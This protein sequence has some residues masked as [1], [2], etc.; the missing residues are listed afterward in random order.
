MKPT[1]ATTSLLLVLAL[2]LAFVACARPPGGNGQDNPGGDPDNPPGS[3]GEVQIPDS[4]VSALFDD[5]EAWI[6][7]L[8][9]VAVGAF[10]G[11]VEFVVAQSEGGAQACVGVDPEAGVVVEG[12]T[13]RLA[14]RFTDLAGSG[15]C[16][17][18]VTGNVAECNPGGSVPRTCAMTG[19]TSSVS[20]GGGQSV[21][22]GDGQITRLSKCDAFAVSLETS[23]EWA[24][25]N[26]HP[27][28]SQVIPSAQSIGAIVL[29]A[30]NGGETVAANVV[31]DEVNVVGC[32]DENPS[33]PVTLSGGRLQIGMELQ[34]Q[35]NRDNAGTEGSCGIEFD[36]VVSYCAVMEG[37]S[38][39]QTGR[40]VRFDGAGR[41]TENDR[42]GPLNT[43]YMILGPAG[44]P[45]R[46]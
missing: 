46:R 32:I 18:D 4:D 16:S 11:Q 12:E 41:W 23:G 2:P 33:S 39:S 28:S 40:L 24:I 27:V 34:G 15:T 14:T 42:G 43:L 1:I 5:D 13:M 9:T 37:A 3:G 35:D 10:G 38:F 20:L 36:G 6:V 31:T 26:T 30:G 19:V 17:A 25:L 45:G 22:P 7:S 29:V 21:A 8:P 44:A